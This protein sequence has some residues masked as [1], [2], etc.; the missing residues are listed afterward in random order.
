MWG[1][2]VG[3][4]KGKIALSTTVFIEFVTR[5][6]NKYTYNTFTL[7]NEATYNRNV[8]SLSHREG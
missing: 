4:S 5:N 6:F 2:G 3:E 7:I 1:R 8:Y